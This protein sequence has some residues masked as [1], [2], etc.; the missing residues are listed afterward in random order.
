MTTMKVR[1]E[2]L[3]AWNFTIDNE[4]PDSVIRLYIS[5]EDDIDI[6]NEKGYFYFSTG[7]FRYR[8]LNELLDDLC[9]EIDDNRYKVMNVEIE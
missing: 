4:M 3:K 7:S 6:W 1:E 5:G 9:K 8:G 2:I